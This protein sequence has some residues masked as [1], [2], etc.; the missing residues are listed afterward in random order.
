L[1]FI[2]LSKNVNVK[3]KLIFLILIISLIELLSI[4]NSVIGFEV[5]LYNIEVDKD[6]YYPNEIIK[7]IA[8][9]TLDYNPI[10]EEA[11]VQV[12][13]SD[14]FDIV[15]WNSSKY[16]KIGNFT[17]NWS[18]NI[19][20][21]NLTL[22]NHTRY[23][24][25]KFLSVYHQI[26]TMEIISNFLET[27]KVKIRK[28]IPFCQLIG[29]K[30]Q[31][32]YGDNL[33][34]QARFFDN[35]IENNSFLNNQLIIFLIR[36]NNSII[37]QSNFT[38]NYLGS[39]DIFIS[40]VD[41]LNLG[42]NKLILKL[43]NNNVYNDSKFQYEVF[44]KRNPIYIDIISFKEDLGKHEDMI[45]K[46]FYYYFFNNTLYPLENQGIELIILGDQNITYTQVYNTD[47]FGILSVAV[48]YESL[49]S[50]KEI[51]EFKL[52]LIFNGSLYLENKTLSLNLNINIHEIESVVQLNIVLFFSISAIILLISLAILFKFKKVKKKVLPDITIRY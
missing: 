9:W 24:Y 43:V 13:I 30:D 41:H 20:F 25:I 29:F 6:N 32:T 31:I 4:S 22:K 26:G 47:L 38:T 44:L 45:I 3:K 1:V 46:L 11:Y 18:V 19:D 50:N 21:L 52:K 10:N 40:S 37:F 8:S 33:I 14:E 2:V 17:K 5:N 28:R 51:K 34:F 15:I 27:I 39:I 16:D 36:S 12:R 35:L 49:H 23:L 7:I 42:V 48:S